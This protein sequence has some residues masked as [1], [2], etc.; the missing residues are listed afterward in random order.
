MPK[1]VRKYVIRT[2]DDKRAAVAA[3]RGGESRAEVAARLGVP[4]SLVDAWCKKFAPGESLQH[5]KPGKPASKANGL[6]K[7]GDPPGLTPQALFTS[8]VNRAIVSLRQAYDE[9]KRMERQGKI[10]GP[11]RAHTLAYMALLELQGD[12]SL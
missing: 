2:D 5:G 8:R 9:V 6:A 7:T 11:D 10:K 12:N 3:V 4:W 1:K